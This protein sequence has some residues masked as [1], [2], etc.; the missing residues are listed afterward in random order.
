MC[1][2]SVLG[3]GEVERERFSEQ[4]NINVVGD[5]VDGNIVR[6]LTRTIR[7]QYG[8]DPQAPPG[9]SL[10]ILR[11]ANFI[12]DK[13]SSNANIVEYPVNWRPP[14][15]AASSSSLTTL[16]RSRSPQKISKKGAILHKASSVGGKNLGYD[17]FWLHLD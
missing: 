10:S 4:E 2:S 16:G 15:T 1:S 14:C 3:V 8:D 12:C 5:A 9:W 7:Q 13:L 11:A 6:E 17:I